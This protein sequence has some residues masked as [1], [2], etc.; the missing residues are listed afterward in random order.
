[1]ALMSADT[2]AKAIG[3]W[4]IVVSIAVTPW[5]N[6]DPVSVTKLFTVTVIAS[7]VFFFKTINPKSFVSS[8]T[9]F[10]KMVTL[11]VF[12]T[13]LNLILKSQ[14]PSER[15]FG[16]TGRNV[17]ALFF[18]SMLI[19]LLISN[20]SFKLQ[21]GKLLVSTIKI[22]SISVSIYFVVQKLGLD[23]AQ[24]ADAYGGVP[25]STL[26]NPNFV[27]SL[28]AIGFSVTLPT[29]LIAHEKLL[30]RAMIASISILEFYVIIE[31]NSAQGV[32][33]VSIGIFLAMYVKFL[34]VI[35]KH[36][37]QVYRYSIGIIAITV[38]SMLILVLYFR[39]SLATNPTLL[40]RFVYWRAA[41]SMILNSPLYG[42]G[43]DYYGESYLKFRSTNDAVRFW[44]LFSDS[45]HNYFLDIGVFS[46]LVVLISFLIPFVMSLFKTFTL[47]FVS[48][49]Q[50][51][52]FESPDAIVLGLAIALYGFTFQALISP[53]SH[54]LFYIGVVLTG[55]LNS[56]L[57]SQ[58]KAPTDIGLY[59]INRVFKMKKNLS[60]DKVKFAPPKIYFFGR[61]ASALSAIAI[62]V[63]GIQPMM[64]D[65]KFRDAIEQGNG[66]KLLTIAL[67]QPMSSDRMET[68]AQIFVENNRPDLALRVIRSM[69][70]E[71]SGN[72]RGWRLLLAT[73][74]QS[75]ERALA[76]EKIKELDPKNPLLSAELAANP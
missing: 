58:D 45:A 7:F 51:K 22:S 57:T 27:S 39:E 52:K 47:F 72:I 49:S 34:V 63:L 53:I 48:R 32:I 55:F 42:Q 62:L 19:I 30:L 44:G 70:K 66:D 3:V 31:S 36:N 33:I 41:F 18:I 11:G 2:C 67:S 68:T 21:H 14:F 56:A 74:T 23:R 28:V 46:G 71:N 43:F 26:G 54:A 75:T 76:R 13:T 40:A 59:S 12:F 6:L 4:I 69:V 16:V 20:Q 38:S 8:S 37:F 5:N 35:A 29:L 25:S 15:I 50:Q 1:M 9:F 24:W 73:S 17:G 65:A 61:V 64:T 10:D 60:L